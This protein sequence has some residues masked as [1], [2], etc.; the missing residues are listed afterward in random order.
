MNIIA[1][2]EDLL[3]VAAGMTRDPEPKITLAKED[4][5]IMHSIARQVFKGT[6]LTDRQFALM[7]EK[8]SKYKDQFEDSCD[9]ESVV[10][11]LRNPLREIDRSKYIK[12]VSHSEMV[13]PDNPYES[14]KQK[15]QWIKVRFP[16]SKSTIT[17]IQNIPKADQYQEYVHHKGSHEHFFLLTEQ[18]VYNIIKTFKEKNFEIDNDLIDLYETISSINK[19]DYE[20]SV[21]DFKLLNMHKNGAAQ[22]QQDLGELNTDNVIHYKDRS[23]LYGITSFDQQAEDIIEGYDILTK[24][25]A[26]RNEPLIHVDSKAWTL[27]ALFNSLISLNRYPIVILLDDTN[28]YDVLAESFGYLRNLIDSREISVLYRLPSDQS[29]GYNEFIQQNKLNNPL[30]SNTKIVYTSKNKINKPL[31]LSECNPITVLSLCKTRRSSQLDNWLVNFDLVIDYADEPAIVPY[32]LLNKR[33][34]EVI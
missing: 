24:R 25:I 11:E 12:I 22:I 28:P 34:I 27:S 2:I 33:K 19:N 10:T 6:A 30:D 16:F 5:T 21:K 20:I 14:Y 7:K 13:G 31:V 18:N 3:E 17:L 32:R 29:N 26:R 1:T 15:W 8:L 23:I 4:I 9:F